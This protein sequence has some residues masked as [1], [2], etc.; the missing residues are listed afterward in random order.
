MVKDLGIARGLF[1]EEGYVAYGD[2]DCFNHFIY[3]G[4]ISTLLQKGVGR[5]SSHG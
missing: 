1:F 2:F 4:Y 3:A 5:S